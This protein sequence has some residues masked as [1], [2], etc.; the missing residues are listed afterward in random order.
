MNPIGEVGIKDNSRTYKRRVPL[1]VA[2]QRS[3]TYG[4]GRIAGDQSDY[5]NNARDT[6]LF[7]LRVKREGQKFSF[8]IGEW[9]SQRHIRKWE[10]TFRDIDN[11]YQGK[12]KYVTL[13]IG[14][15]QD[16]V[17]PSRLRINSVEVFELS[18]TEEDQTPYI[19]YPGDIVT[20][21]HVNADVLLN[22][23]LSKDTFFGDFFEL[24]KDV[25]TLTV[26]PSNT[27][28]AQV[29]FRERWR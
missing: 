10:G 23:E 4:Q 9:Q 25:N 21:D 26:S 19:I 18:Q 15:Y 16:R 7:Y 17:R 14:S 27:F 5:T 20:F 2:G 22:G 13:F 1:A 3:N 24:N 6:T 28:D 11:K 12:L 8:Y 29:K